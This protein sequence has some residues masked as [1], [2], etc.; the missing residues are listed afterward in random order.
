MKSVNLA[1]WRCRGL[2]LFKLR[3][4]RGAGLYS[5]KARSWMGASGTPPE[6]LNMESKE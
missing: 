2:W 1:C 4:L 3:V 6:A 5:A